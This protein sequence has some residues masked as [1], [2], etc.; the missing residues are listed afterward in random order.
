MAAFRSDIL[1][2]VSSGHDDG[3][4]TQVIHFTSEVDAR[5][6]ERKEP[7]AELQAV[8]GEMVEIN[9]G[10]PDHMDLRR[11][12]LESLRVRAPRGTPARL[13]G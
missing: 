8:R 9:D 6:G 11:P 4:W 13:A 2:S 1:G 3:R 5:A 12:L 10:P 7:P